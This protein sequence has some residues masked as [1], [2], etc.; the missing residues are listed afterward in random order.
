M[1]VDFI[2]RAD[3]LG[4]A[5]ARG[6]LWCVALLNVA[7]LIL[8]VATSR[9][10]IDRNGFLLGTDFISFWTTGHMLQSG[11]NVYDTSAHIA[12]QR[13]FFQ[14][15]DAYTAFFYP[16]L[17][18]PICYNL[19]YLGYFPALGTWLV[20]TGAMFVQGVRF[21]ARKLDFT[22]PLW[23]AVAAFPPVLITLTH[24]QTSFLAA[25]FL[26]VGLLRLCDRPWAGGFLLGIAAI[27]P[28][29]GL[30]VPVALL[31][32]GQW[33]TIIAAAITVTVFGL[34]ATLISGPAVW[35]DWFAVTRAAQAAMAEGAV[36]FA[37]MQSL[38]AATRLL[39]AS[40]GVAYA[41]Q[42]VLTT[43][44]VATVA[45]TAWR[46]GYNAGVAA[47]ILAGAPLATPFV[48]DYDMVLLAFPLIWL[49]AEALRQ[50]FYPWEKLVFV[51]TFIA[52]AFARPLAMFVGVPIMPV[53]LIAFFIF[54]LRRANEVPAPA[55]WW[56]AR[57]AA[58]LQAT[59]ATPDRPHRRSPGSAAASSPAGRAAARPARRAAARAAAAPRP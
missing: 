2:R 33:R 30:L 37:K 58:C 3:W 57:G 23:T 31:L 21:W 1:G 17:F 10:G 35:A 32:T 43:A 52:G 56:P 45:W 24:G 47:L 7:A 27:K 51:L 42:G 26:G 53:I 5:R 28:Q 19:G 11:G 41:I 22:L 8:L 6:Y 46:Q 9:G 50:G 15:G 36:P 29:F 13:A 49:A 48:L 16:P 59:E 4:E 39:G 38:F 18:L 20:V 44:V 40:T 54:V 14:Q 55:E 12:A 34:A 25:S